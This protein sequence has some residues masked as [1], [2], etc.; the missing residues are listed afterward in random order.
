M[1]AKGSPGRKRPNLSV[2]DIPKAYT[3]NHGAPMTAFGQR[4]SVNWNAS[5]NNSKGFAGIS[6]GARKAQ[7]PN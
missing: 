4:P 6:L 3:N 1:T 5:F 2:Y 7:W